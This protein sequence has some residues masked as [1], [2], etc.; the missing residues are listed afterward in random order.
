MTTR[1]IEGLGLILSSADSRDDKIIRVLM[2]DDEM[3]PTVVKQGRRAGGR[4]SKVGMVQPLTAVRVTLRSKPG[5]ELAVL[6]T[7]MV[8]QAFAVVKGDLLRLALATCMTEVVLHLCPDWGRESGL[9]GLLSRALDRLNRPNESPGEDWLLLFELKAL[10]A[11]GVLPVIDEWAEVPREG[12]DT[13]QGWLEG[14]WAPLDPISA[15]VSGRL[16]ENALTAASGRAFR[17][18]ALLNEALR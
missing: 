10:D 9:Y 17:S 1:R 8:E 5:V 11:A 16:L 13:L 12:R 7:V 6:E 2:E 18:R 15:R 3:V 14:K 4:S